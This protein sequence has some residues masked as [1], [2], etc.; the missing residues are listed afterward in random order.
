[1]KQANISKNRL[2]KT[3]MFLTLLITAV[4]LF[5]STVPAAMQQ[6]T[7]T[8][9]NNTL[10][11]MTQATSHV[12]AATALK[13]TIRHMT[14]Q[15]PEPLAQGDVI[16][17]QMPA[18]YYDYW[19]AYTSA[20]LFPYLVQE[21]F[22]GLSDSIGGITFWGLDL[23]YNYGWYQGDPTGQT[24]D[25]Q[26]YND[27]GG[28]PGSSVADFPGMTT[29]AYPYESWDGY[30][31]NWMWSFSELGAIGLD[32][33]WVSVQSTQGAAD[34]SVFLWMS[35]ATGNNNA[36][37]NGGNL[38]NNVAFN[39]TAGGAAPPD[40]VKIVS[41]DQPSSGMAQIVAP[42]IKVKNVGNN[43]ET[44]P[45]EYTITHPVPPMPD[46]TWI[47]T[48]FDDW[49]GVDWP[50]WSV[51]VLDGYSGWHGVTTS[52]WPTHGPH[53]GTYQAQYDSF[54]EYS[55]S[56]SML[57]TNNP[58]DTMGASTV[59]FTYWMYHDTAY[60]GS[61]DFTAPMFS[62]DGNT[63]Y[64]FAV[65][66]RYDGSTGWTQYSYN[67]GAY[68]T[69][70][71]WYGFYAYSGYGNNMCI[72]DFSV[73]SPGFQPPPVVD[74]D[75]SVP[76][77]LASGATQVVTLPD[78]TPPG[79]QTLDNQDI[80]F[81]SVATA[82]LPGDATPGN[83]VKTKDFTMHYPFL[84][85]IQV[86]GI[87]S[88]TESGMAKT[89]PVKLQISNQG[90]FPERDFFVHEVIGRLLGNFVN[91]D[92]S[93]GVPPAG[94]TVDVSNWQ[95]SASNYAGGTAPE[96]MFNWY[97]S[98]VGDFR[99]TTNV[100]DTSGQTNLQFSFRDSL[101]HFGG[102]YTLAVQTTTNG[103]ATWN[104]IW[105]RVNPSSSYAGELNTMVLT[106][107]DGI[108]S[109]NFQMCWLFSGT[110]FNINYWYVDDALMQAPSV[111]TEYDESAAISNWLQPGQSVQLTYPDWTPLN[112]NVGQT[113][114]TFD[115]MAIGTSMLVG[116]TNTAND[117]S[118]ASFQLTYVHDVG[119]KKITSPSLQKADDVYLHFDDGTTTNSIGLTS[120]G[121]FESAIRLTPTE[122]GPYAGQT[123]DSIHVHYGYPDGTPGSAI[124]G[125]VKIYDAG[126]STAPGAVL[127]TQDFTTP[128]TMVWFDIPLTTPVSID[129]SK[130]MWISTEWQNTQAGQYPAGCDSGPSVPGKGDWVAL[131]GAWVEIS[132]YGLNYNWNLWGHVG[133]GGGP[134]HASIFVKQGTTSPIASIVNNAGT[135]AESGLTC[136]AKILDYVTD[137]VNGTLVYQDSVG[138]ITLAAL[139]GE[140]A[141]TFTSYQFADEGIYGLTMSIPLGND[142]HPSNNV[143]AIFIG[144][145]G[146]PPTTTYSLSPTTPNGNNG[147]YV[148][149]PTF[150]LTATDAMSGVGSIMYSLDG[151]TAQ[152]YTSPVKI[153]TDGNHTIG[154]YAVDKV[155]NI[156]ATKT[157]TVHVDTTMPAITLDKNIL[158][159]KITYI[160]TVS[161]VTSGLD[162]VEFWIGPYLQYTATITT[163]Y[164][165]QTASWTLTPIPNIN[166]NITA[167]VFDLAGNM[168]S[169][170]QDP[171]NLNLPTGQSQQ[172]HSQTTQ[173]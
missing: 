132:V 66:Y 166:V 151:A 144:S 106:T 103:G 47:S 158:L 4:M 95:S 33:G 130:D 124:S 72:D 94:W 168:N 19:N 73:T 140:Q 134:G 159:N 39:L 51:Y 119:V 22:Y 105:S 6:N 143:K 70:P 56:D 9:T 59:I 77:T 81:N 104:T 172:A 13:G 162:R 68:A 49:S 21:D 11:S 149:D 35:S 121:T 171:L 114:G 131:N 107:A 52:S 1:M 12:S 165:E 148:T 10:S 29:V 125:A 109:P 45:V 80:S 155:G 8:K 40:D 25:I 97:P 60:S 83:N 164:G 20:S 53:S 93:G 170:Q 138:G 38:G 58:I 37:Q 7:P 74:Y 99:M 26:F 154:Y 156:E 101:N 116:D 46:T 98:L 62:W 102:P 2:V 152:P 96:A 123:I 167:K 92:F 90:Q 44:F 54:N 147:W 108:G 82:Y 65:N 137:P 28:V 27:N 153:T 48:S 34:G 115:Y 32:T 67:I 63:F 91:Q 15:T 169:A 100:I 14:P 112:L 127:Y 160:A 141:L 41:I 128:T 78:F 88:P 50:G 84:H 64:Y 173:D 36:E 117:Q 146:T 110:T 118:L 3:T 89:Y 157:F 61:S 86:D 161:D 133:S 136:D 126:S 85:D 142:D 111:V 76:V 122:L 139:G 79:Y 18:G 71:L 135:F 5:S 24:F 31:Y 16:F 87:L 42:Q 30:G 163:P 55:G 23:I 145:D 43:S 120:G 129:G 113:S 57:V 17:S 75:Q 150:T 69:S